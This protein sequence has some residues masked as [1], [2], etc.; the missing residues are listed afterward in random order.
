MSAN[1]NLSSATLSPI[2]SIGIGADVESS[3]PC[4]PSSEGNS[5][6]KDSLLE[7]D[8]LEADDE[9]EVLVRRGHSNA[10]LTTS[11]PFTKSELRT[12]EELV[13]YTID[14][15]C[16][17][18]VA[19]A[20]S[21]TRTSSQDSVD[22]KEVDLNEEDPRPLKLRSTSG[23]SSSASPL[24]QATAPDAADEGE[25]L[26]NEAHEAE[27]ENPETQTP[28]D[29]QGRDAAALEREMS[30]ISKLMQRTGYPIV[31]L[32]RLRR[33]GPPPDWAGQSPPRGTEVFV[34]KIPRDCFE[35]ELV[36]VLE[37]AGKIYELRLMADFNGFNRGYAFVVYSTPVEAKKCVKLFNNYEIR[38]G[39][40][41]HVSMSIDNCRLFIGGIPNRV[42][43][44][45]ILK[46]FEKVR[47][48]RLLIYIGWCYIHRSWYNLYACAMKYKSPAL[49][50]LL[51]SHVDIIWPQPSCIRLPIDSVH[52][53]I[54]RILLHLCC[55]MRVT[56]MNSCQL[57][58]VCGTQGSVNPILHG[59]II[60]LCFVVS[61]A[62][63]QSMP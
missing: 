14:I 18:F 19:G 27:A 20:D 34:G 3:E 40:L 54:Y 10:A 17:G 46:E 32:G 49:S 30:P 43:K 8:K 9:G 35:D 56:T 38:K 2:S 23:K 59:R 15:D 55:W 51:N 7:E 6:A 25:G 47:V 26:F 61:A 16:S 53:Y 24:P 36:P 48:A 42:V 50:L 11:T 44:D 37:Q 41:L 13:T 52:I 62:W 60:H 33:Y 12:K 5:Y 57:F 4:S 29:K 58:C 39:R 21:I 1:I 31:Q 22:G 28:V 63:G 45:D